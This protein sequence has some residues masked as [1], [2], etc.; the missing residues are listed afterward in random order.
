MMAATA[1]LTI[2]GIYDNSKHHKLSV[3]SSP[4]IFCL[5]T[6]TKVIYVYKEFLILFGKKYC[7]EGLTD[8]IQ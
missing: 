4:S 1:K 2:D 8:Q 7:I 3:Q 5:I 6:L